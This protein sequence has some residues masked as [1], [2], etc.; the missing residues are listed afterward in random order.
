MATDPDADR[1]GIAVKNDKGEWILL[2][3]NQT[4]SLLINYMI[5]AWSDAG[6]ITGKEYVVK[7]IVT[8]DILSKIASRNNVA[9]YN[10]LT[11][12][13][14]IAAKIK[15]LE[16]KEKFIVG[17]EESYGYLIGDAVRDKDAIA[18]CAFIAEMAAVA[19]DKGASLYETMVEMYVT[20]GFYKEKLIS[21]TKKG[22]SGA[23][24]IQ[25]MMKNLRSNPPKYLAGS[26][27][28]KLF[29]YEAQIEKDFITGKETKIDLPKE[30]VLQ[31]LTEDESLISAR[32]SGTEPKIKFYMSVNSVLGSSGDYNSV[33]ETLDQ[34][35]EIIKKD[36]K[37]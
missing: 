27:V 4:G 28:K 5:N 9:C 20:Y 29:D 10:T 34:K 30:N 15:E 11:G 1:V 18:S 3:G 2:N 36:L 21:I 13:K 25:E 7:T 22:K 8:S 17:G 16:G 31:F 14:Y 6:K 37:L 35:I 32:P 12:F 33:S 19:K 23:E 24:E 26:Q